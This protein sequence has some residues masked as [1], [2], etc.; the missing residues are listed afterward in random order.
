MILL[1]ASHFVGKGLHRECYRHPD[2][3]QL[4]VKVVVA[5][6]LSESKREQSYYKLLQKRDIC[7]DILPRF[8]GLIE[9][10][11]GTGAVFDLIRDYDEEV[12]KTLAHYLS[13]EQ[14]AASENAGLS[15]AITVFKQELH[16]Q[17]IITMTISP[18]NIMYKKTSAN[19]GRLIII[20][21]IGNSDFIPICS[22]VTYLAKKKIARKLLR[23]E[24]TV[25]K[26]CGHNKAL[27]KH[28]LSEFRA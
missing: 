22:Y 15:Q 21:N 17:A 2:D 12:S 16:R 26:M 7:W 28:L 3:T 5:G 18:K 13:Y 24:D 19:S 23:F 6:D 11:M 10:N 27:S 20:D 9:T 8:H 1:N 14:L 25:L 4:C